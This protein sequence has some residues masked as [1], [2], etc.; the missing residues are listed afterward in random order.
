MKPNRNTAPA[1]AHAS[2]MP[3][4]PARGIGP[5]MTTV[6]IADR[7]GKLHK[8]VLRDCRKMLAALG[9]DG[10]NFERT[11]TDDAGKAAKCFLLPEREILILTSGYSIALRAKIVDR[12]RELEHASRP[13]PA[14]PTTYADALRLAAEQAETVERQ[15]A[16]I[17]AQRPAVAVVERITASVASL[18][19]TEA[20]KLLR[21]S[22]SKLFAFLAEKGWTYRKGG[23]GRWQAYQSAIERGVLEHDAYLIATASGPAE[24]YQLKVTP[25]GVAK[26]AAMMVGVQLDLGIES[27]ETASFLS[28]GGR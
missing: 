11:Y 19:V 9:D 1:P 4:T 26:L 25:K 17:E 18:S 14:I 7:T 13:A 20:S 12:L 5:T 27:T 6:E 21:V 8:N 24:S 3:V 16:I 10:L 23:T 2:P 15:A 22:P 28:G